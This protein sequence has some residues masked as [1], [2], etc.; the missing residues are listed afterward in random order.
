MKSWESCYCCLYRD[1]GLKWLVHYKLP[2]HAP[3]NGRFSQ[4]KLLLDVILSIYPNLTGAWPWH[5][6]VSFWTFYNICS[7]TAAV[8][9][10][11]KRCHGVWKNSWGQC[12][13]ATADDE[14]SAA[15]CPFSHYAV[16][17][18]YL[19]ELLQDKYCA[20]CIEALLK[21][22]MYDSLVG[23]RILSGLSGKE[24]WCA[25][26]TYLVVWTVQPL[27][28]VEKQYSEKGLQAWT[29]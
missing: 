29:C 24:K 5:S 18:W 6:K 15:V 28:L 3:R 20:S 11:W 22:L 12:W 27:T 25:C 19:V 26:F 13:T 14:A 16:F 7:F 10:K 17:S 8:Q 21:S 2:E 1:Q 23:V 4:V 9:R